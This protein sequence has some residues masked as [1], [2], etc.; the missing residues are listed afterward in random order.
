MRGALDRSAE[1]NDEKPQTPYGKLREGL[2]FYF[3]RGKALPQESLRLDD[4]LVG[5]TKDRLKNAGR[6]AT[7]SVFLMR[8]LSADLYEIRRDLRTERIMDPGIEQVFTMQG[9]DRFFD[10][11]AAASKAWWRCLLDV[12]E[13]KDPVDLAEYYRQRYLEAWGTWLKELSLRADTSKG[14]DQLTKSDEALDAL[15]RAR[16]PEL[17]EVFKNFGWGSRMAYNPSWL[18][19]NESI[20]C[21][22]KVGGA[23]RRI[24][25]E[26]TEGTLPGECRQ[27]MAQLKP[28]SQL[29]L[30]KPKD[31]ESSSDEDPSSGRGGE[32]YGK[33]LETGQKLH[34]TLGALRKM[35]PNKKPEVSLTLV[36]NTMESKGP[37]FD[38]DDA[39]LALLADLRGRAAKMGIDLPSAGFNKLLERIEADIWGALLEPAAIRLDNQWSTQ[40]LADWKL[41][42][43]QHSRYAAEDPEICPKIVEFVTNKVK[44]FSQTSLAAFYEGTNPANCRL[45]HMEGGPFAKAIPLDEKACFKVQNAIKI[46][47]QTHCEKAMGA[48][49][50]A[51]KNKPAPTKADVSSPTGGGCRYNVISAELDDGQQLHAC[52]ISSEK[53][54]HEPSQE[55]R[56]R[57]RVQWSENNTYDLIYQGQGDDYYSFLKRHADVKNTS[58]KFEIPPEKARGNCQGFH[59]TFTIPASAGGGGGSGNPDNDWKKIELP[60]SLL[61]RDR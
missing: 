25:R 43:D 8:E 12:E 2:R 32:L 36:Q 53:C 1:A 22:S 59:V 50:G 7:D 40:V 24:K 5:A 39:R 60:A 35:A 29:L 17:S 48:A 28:F 61:H 30:P 16:S 26:I 31:A 6:E 49:G 14:S 21:M 15:T 56:P 37:L 44:P 3:Q 57:L 4:G 9:C 34:G 20:G 11:K 27:A 19:A 51:G 10:K 52:S 18:T 13:P 54:R 42:K 33:L 47:G 46:A 41:L 23:A 58:L 45:T 38:F 55:K